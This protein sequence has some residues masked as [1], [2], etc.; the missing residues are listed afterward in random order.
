[1]K[2]FGPE[3]V[4]ERCH[5]VMNELTRATLRKCGLRNTKLLTG[6]ASITAVELRHDREPDQG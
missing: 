2:A 1:M 3:A 4:G 6:G 5:H